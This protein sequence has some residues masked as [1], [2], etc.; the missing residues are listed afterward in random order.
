MMIGLACVL[1]GCAGGKDQTSM[2]TEKDAKAEAVAEYRAV[3]GLD[4][5]KLPTAIPD[6][7]P[8]PCSDD[9]ESGVRFTYFLAV[10]SPEA[11]PKSLEA[12][13]AA[14]WRSEGY[15]LDRHTEPFAQGDG[16]VYSIAANADGKP[17]VSLGVSTVGLTLYVHS[18]CASGDMSSYE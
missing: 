11:D 3:V 13:V 4:G 5:V 9:G 6:P 7:V 8:A 14:H 1:A 10:K 17:R 12:S 2:L 18:R 16:E 15:E